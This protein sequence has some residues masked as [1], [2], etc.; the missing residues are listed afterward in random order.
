MAAPGTV[1]YRVTGNRELIDLVTI[2]Y[3]DQRGALQ[4]EMNVA[5][6]WSKTIVLDPGVTLSSV[7]ATSVRGQLNCSITD[8]GGNLIASQNSNSI[9]TNCTR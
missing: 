8:A 2:I 3:T 9:I 5:L 1:T 7:T 6:P 4:T